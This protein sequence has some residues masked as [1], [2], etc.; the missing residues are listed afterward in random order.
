MAVP[1]IGLLITDITRTWTIQQWSGVLEGARRRGASLITF[2]GSHLSSPYGFNAQANVLYQLARS[3][4]INGLV[5][6]TEGLVNYITE[7]EVSEFF[8]RFSPLPLVSVEHRVDGVPNILNDDFGAMRSLIAHLIEVH[9]YR[10]IAYI[11]HATSTHRAF[12]ERYRGYVET[13]AEHGIPFDPALVSPP[14]EAEAPPVPLVLSEW[15][16]RGRASEWNAIIAHNDLAA[17]RVIRDLRS[18]GLPGSSAPAVTGFDDSEEGAVV[19]PSL[20]TIRPPFREMGVAAAETLLDMI[21]GKPVEGARTLQGELVLRRSCGC[22]DPAVAGAAAATRHGKPRRKGLPR[23]GQPRGVILPA[24]LRKHIASSIDVKQAWQERLL[25]D[26]VA[27]IQGPQPGAF[28]RRLEALVNGIPG[29]GEMVPAINGWLSELRGR[30][31]PLLDDES[32]RR[33]EDLFHRAQVLIGGAGQRQQRLVTLEALHR[34]AGLREVEA[35]LFTK[36]SV[37]SLMDG[38]A[39]SLPRIGVHGFALSLYEDP[40][41]YSYPDQAPEFSRLALAFKSD[42]RFNVAPGGQRFPT[43]LLAPPQMWPASEPFNLVAESLYCQDHQLGFALFEVGPQEGVIY[44]SLRAVIS[45]DLQGARLVE[46]EQRWTRQLQENER[47][48]RQ[49]ES[50]LHQAQKIEAVGQLAGGVAHE[51]NNI[52]TAIM[53]FSSVLMMNMAK[54]DPRRDLVERT[55]AASRRAADLAQRMLILGR[56]DSSNASAMDL[57]E[58]T[59]TSC[60][61]LSAA[62]GQKIELKFEPWR[63]SVPVLADSMRID[64]IL[65]NLAANAR[66]AMPDGG[67]VLV[68]LSCEQVDPSVQ[69]PDLQ[70]GVYAHL[71]F[72]DTGTGMDEMTRARLFEPFFT[73]K[74]VGK[75]TGLGLAIV[76]AIVEQHHGFIKVESQLGRGTTFDIFLPIH[77]PAAPAVERVHD[78]TSLHGSETILVAAGDGAVRAQIRS[79]LERHG[80]SVIE[81]ADGEDVAKRFAQHA[82]GIHLVLLDTMMAK[83]DGWEVAL[84]IRRSTPQA[85]IVFMSEYAPS[86]FGREPLRIDDPRFLPKPFTVV[87]LLEKVRKALD[88]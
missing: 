49:L 78:V 41:L 5:V 68:R 30:T 33:A 28:I 19:N 71:A 58:A 82:K 66:D 8:G 62:L 55:I 36:F 24:D 31:V 10:R 85:K 81:A 80:Y 43:R 2:D 75:G 73:T 76:W 11:K 61:S 64:Q 20:T 45:N 46:Q 87:Q 7:A 4:R 59:R 83:I 52:L 21:E 17:L 32:L 84:E 70:P 16:Q 15:M 6:W 25:E 67:T 13:L 74:D 18:L 51:F 22:M 23:S 12:D 9:G 79:A 34:E 65:V 35:S 48:R 14:V 3:E 40:P 86:R 63:E 26:F 72:S 54:D 56:K 37:T 60:R 39:E 50:M 88:E 77:G 42:R 44:E 1:T 47:E 53:G 69:A 29:A 27:E 38:L 57:N